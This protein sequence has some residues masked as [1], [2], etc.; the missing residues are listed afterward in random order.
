MI[1]VIRQ[2]KKVIGKYKEFVS[3][4][5]IM[6]MSRTDLGKYVSDKLIS[7]LKKDDSSDLFSYSIIE[8]NE[9]ETPDLFGVYIEVIFEFVPNQI[10]MKE[11]E[12]VTERLEIGL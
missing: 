1:D 10:L 8:I 5:E 3:N 9:L 4:A 12:L 11:I 6:V 7:E 2:G